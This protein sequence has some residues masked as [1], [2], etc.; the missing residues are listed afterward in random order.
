VT[1][2]LIFQLTSFGRWTWAVYVATHLED[3]TS[4]AT[5]IKDL[6]GR[7][8]YRARCDLTL[9]E[10]YTNTRFGLAK[11]VSLSK[12]RRRDPVAA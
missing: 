10:S 5:I 3:E 9:R 7:F 11:H 4:R 8:A 1:W 12:Q 6:I 2:S